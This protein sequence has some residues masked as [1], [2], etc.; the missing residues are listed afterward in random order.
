[1]TFPENLIDR[2]GMV[3]LN[4][5]TLCLTLKKMKLLEAHRYYKKPQILCYNELK[6]GLSEQMPESLINAVDGNYFNG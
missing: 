1:M 5:F 4:W 3:K 6:W 2:F